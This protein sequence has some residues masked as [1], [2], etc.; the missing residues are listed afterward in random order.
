[1]PY[2]YYDS[3]ITFM[4]LIVGAAIVFY[5]QIKISSNYSKY[6]KIS[7][8]IKLSGQEIARAILDNNNL[9]NVHIVETSGN[10]SDHYDPSR[11]VIKLSKEIFNGETIAASAVAAHEVGH[12]IQ[13]KEGYIFMRI[14]SVL[15][16]FVNIVNYLGYFVIIIGVLA[17]LTGYLLMGILIILI[18]LIFQLITLPV[19][20][21]ASKRALE[22]L[23]KIGNYD[24]GTDVMLRAA[25]FTYVASVI[26][27]LL[28]LLRLIIIFNKED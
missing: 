18:T 26:S 3:A 20:F 13:D 27:S 17:G 23:K 8:S 15:V 16:P 19:E 4:L 22:E 24:E 21:D 1:M 28:N 12:A 9:S 6:K 2:L 7:N 25:A 14:R 10:L 11:K 5:A